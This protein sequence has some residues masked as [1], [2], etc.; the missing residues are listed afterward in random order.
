MAPNCIELC[1]NGQCV[2]A[3]VVFPIPFD[4][5]FFFFFTVKHCI[6]LN[7]T[8]HFLQPEESLTR[9]I[10]PLTCQFVWVIVCFHAHV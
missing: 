5:V 9:F 7:T 1:V 2:I 3:L 6:Q 8:I 4:A 10:S